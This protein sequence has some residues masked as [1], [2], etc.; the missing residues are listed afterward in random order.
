[1][2]PGR[3]REIA[4]S[5]GRAAHAQG[6]AHEF[7]PQEARAAGRKSQSLRHANSMAIRPDPMPS[8]E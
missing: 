8:Q 7:T 3:V 6:V 5:G 4:R 2:E 1:M